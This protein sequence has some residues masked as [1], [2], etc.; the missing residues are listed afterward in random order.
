MQAKTLALTVAGALMV[1]VG[2]VFHF[3]FQKSGALSAGVGLGVIL[4]IFA[5]ISHA[6]QKE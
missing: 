3:M 6:T 2:L 4:L 1:I 5:A